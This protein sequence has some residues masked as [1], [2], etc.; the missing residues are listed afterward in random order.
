MTVMVTD[1]ATL[2]YIERV[3]GLDVEAVR[4]RIANTC[5]GVRIAKCVKA[6]GFDYIL[7]DGTVITVKPSQASNPRRVPR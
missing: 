2:R 6:E 7:K 1:H 4:Q 5:R 3:M